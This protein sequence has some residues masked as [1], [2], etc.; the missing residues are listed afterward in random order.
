MSA[1]TP[2]VG[3][4]WKM[5]FSR[6]EAEAF[7]AAL[8]ALPEPRAEVVLFPSFPLIPAVAAGLAGSWAACGGQDLH[9]DPHGAHTGDV[10]EAAGI[11]DRRAAL[12]PSIASSP[13]TSNQFAPP[14]VVAKTWS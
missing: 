6:D 1:R 5:H 2:L 11:A 14:V 3:G 7:C 13:V 4:N 10:S 9:F 8:V 12:V